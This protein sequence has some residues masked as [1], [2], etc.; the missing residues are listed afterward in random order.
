MAFIASGVLIALGGS[1]LARAS[2]FAIAGATWPILHAL[3]HLA[4]WAT[5][6]IPTE[7][8]TLASEA[9][10]VV[11]LAAAGGILAAIRSRGEPS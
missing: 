10:G 6:G 1:G 7:P 5:M 4:G 11:A 3:I 8:R 9:I 2:G